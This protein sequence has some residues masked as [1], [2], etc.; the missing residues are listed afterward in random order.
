MGRTKV[1]EIAQKL[2]LESKEVL[3][4][5]NDMGEFVRSASSTVEPPVLRRLIERLSAAARVAG[6]LPTLQQY[7]PGL[8]NVCQSATELAQRLVGDWLSQYMLS[9]DTE[10]ARQVAEWL[11]DDKTHLSHGRALRLED[12]HAKGVTVSRLEDDPE[13]Q[14][15][16]LTYHHLTMHT[17][18]PR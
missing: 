14:D 7:P 10:K 3:R 9:G 4:H 11:A 2:N 5:L 6:W 12:L 1:Y 13:L 17:P 18:E 16:V 8:L 15:A